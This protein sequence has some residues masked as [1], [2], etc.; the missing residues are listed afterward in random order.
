MVD[1]FYRQD[2]NLSYSRCKWGISDKKNEVKRIAQG[3]AVMEGLRDKTYWYGIHCAF[4]YSHKLWDEW[5]TWVLIS[6][7][8]ITH[9]YWLNYFMNSYS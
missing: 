9:F 6:I 8:F 7:E 1:E 5:G 2:K 4:N 3:H